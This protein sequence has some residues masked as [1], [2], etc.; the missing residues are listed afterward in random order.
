[1]KTIASHNV[2]TAAQLYA[3][4]KSPDRQK[5]SSIKGETIKLA[6]WILYTDSNSKGEEFKLV[7][8]TTEDGRSFCTNSA[9]FVRDFGEAVE[10]FTSMDATFDTVK[11]ASGTSKNGREYISCVVVG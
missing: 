3:L 9:T 11:V 4:V 6:S 8:L 1:M 2:E 7:A 10:M 5:L